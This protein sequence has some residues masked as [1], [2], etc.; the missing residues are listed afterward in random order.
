M[1]TFVISSNPL[2]GTWIFMIFVEYCW[3]G[4]RRDVLHWAGQC[5]AWATS[6]VVHHT[7]PQVLPI[8]VP[9]ERFEQV[10]VD[11]VRPF[12]PDRGF[13]YLLTMIDRT[14]R[15]PEVAAIA[16]TKAET[17][18]QA[19]LGH[20][21]SRFGIPHEVVSDRGAQFTSET[22]RRTLAWL[23]VSVSMTT[24]YHPQANGVV[25][26][27]HQTLKNALRCAVWASE[28]W[29]RSLPWVLLGLRN[30]QKLDTSTSTAEVVF[31]T[32]LRVPGLCFQDLQSPRRSAL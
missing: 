4:M 32:P 28:S 31:G 6:K 9:D 15:W 7:N 20:W 13:R 23:G 24:A 11:I 30:A 21:V 19:F 18:V 12:P 3:Q 29:V 22:W 27:F 26:R 25:E 2:N 1:N 14:T 5:K 17:V 8:P 16:D 10:H